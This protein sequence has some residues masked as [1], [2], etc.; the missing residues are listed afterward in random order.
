MGGIAFLLS[1]TE[2]SSTTGSTPVS[3][4]RIRINGYHFN[5]FMA[6]GFITNM[7]TLTL[8]SRL[9]TVKSSH[10]LE[11]RIISHARSYILDV[12]RKGL[13]KGQLTI[14][15]K[16]KE[17]VFGV[18]VLGTAPVTLEVVNDRFW[19]R[20]FLSSDLGLAEAYMEN[21]FEVSSLKDMMNLWLDNCDSLRGLSSTISTIFS[22]YSSVLINFTFRH[23]LKMARAS[24]EFSYSVSNDF[25]KCFLSK[26]MT[27]SSA[28]WGDEENG[29]RG[30]LTMGPTDGD[31]E[32]AQH[33]KIQYCLKKARLRPGD[34]VLEIGCG[35]GA[36]AI[37][38]ARLG[39]TVEAITLST[40]QKLL[41]DIRIAEA[42]FS[43]FITVRLCD[44][45]KLPPEFEHSFDA[46]LSFEMVEAV[47]YKNLGHYF[48]I[49]DWTLKVDRGTAVISSNTQPE[50]R[51][52]VFQHEDF[53]RRYHWPNSYL[54]SPTS[55]LNTLRNSIKGKLVVHTV[56]DLGIHYCRTLREWG[57]RFEKNFKGS[58][59]E[60]MKTK[61]P[62]LQD[63]QQLNAFIR[64]WRYMF[65]YTEMAFSR[66]HNSL[67]YFTLAR[68]ENASEPCA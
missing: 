40:E 56:E 24:A 34:R 31:L 42:G 37:E 45:R 12:L 6:F 22:Y 29:P 39:C 11:R 48:R 67:H 38:A 25:M 68:P 32:A 18:K 47:G 1:S 46:F 50:H 16:N 23:N 53:M 3:I 62:Y 10:F 7:D 44:Y 4:S 63:P 66:A 26:E 60:G 8:R 28:I 41:A 9:F 33:R 15:D 20:L 55:F 61:Y 54:P 36:M 27:Y 30:D 35:W 52:T 65:V 5:G 13:K 17:H 43:D 57:R 21:D 19:G 2:R 59:A 51:Y 49:I 14:V 64:K 58:V